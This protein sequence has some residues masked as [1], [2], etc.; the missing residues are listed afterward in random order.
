MTKKYDPNLEAHLRYVQ[1]QKHTR[2]DVQRAKNKFNAKTT[3]RNVVKPPLKGDVCVSA[4]IK[5]RVRVE[6]VGN[7]AYFT[8]F[9]KDRRLSAPRCRVMKP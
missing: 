3:K 1:S 4:D 2:G 6:T 8:C 9:G 7:T 5:P